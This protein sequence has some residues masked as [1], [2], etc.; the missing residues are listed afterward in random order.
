M[1]SMGDKAFCEGSTYEMDDEWK[2]FVTGPSDI[3]TPSLTR[4]AF[5]SLCVRKVAPQS[6]WRTLGK[7]YGKCNH[8]PALNPPDQTAD[9][10]TL[11]VARRDGKMLLPDHLFAIVMYT[12]EVS[13]PHEQH[14]EDVS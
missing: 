7:E 1:N 13:S 12:R 9:T 2:Y 5:L 4:S 8:A 14:I 11:L 6:E 10:G 3:P